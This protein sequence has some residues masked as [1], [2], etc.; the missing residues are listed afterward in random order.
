VEVVGWDVDW[1]YP[2]CWAPP[3][4][5]RG[6]PPPTPIATEASPSPT[7]TLAS[8]PFP[9]Q[10]VIRNHCKPSATSPLSLKPACCRFDRTVCGQ[11]VNRLYIGG[12]I[13][14]IILIVLLLV[15]LL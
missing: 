9:Q 11:A 1:R 3:A 13:L 8:R 14:V 15:L 5:R 7:P 2:H 10:L 12:G 4:H 6:T